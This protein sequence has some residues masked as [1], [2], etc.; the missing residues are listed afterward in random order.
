MAEGQTMIF[1]VTDVDST[2]G[3]ISIGKHTSQIAFMNQSSDFADIKL[4]GVYTIKIGHG[5]QEAHFYNTIDG[6]YQTFQVLT[7]NVTISAYAL[8]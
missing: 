3:V 2:D 8:G 4:N 5:Q 7:A 6:D 1:A